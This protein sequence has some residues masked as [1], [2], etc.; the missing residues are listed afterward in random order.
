[1]LH[2]LDGAHAGSSAYCCSAGR[3]SATTVTPEAGPEPPDATRLLGHTLGDAHEAAL[4]LLEQRTRQAVAAGAVVARASA[5]A[6]V[7]AVP[8]RPAGA[9]AAALLAR[10]TAKRAGAPSAT[11]ALR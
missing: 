2:P 4:A 7:G 3:K 6:T 9:T 10:V 1:M 5:V 11:Q 8:D